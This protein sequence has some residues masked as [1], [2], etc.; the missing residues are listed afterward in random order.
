MIV[1]IA[2]SVTI[3]TWA[4]GRRKHPK[5]RPEPAGVSTQRHNWER[6]RLPEEPLAIT[7]CVQPVVLGF[8]IRYDLHNKD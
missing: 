8:A 3:V 7:L 5:A 4:V 1:A 6:E 2:A